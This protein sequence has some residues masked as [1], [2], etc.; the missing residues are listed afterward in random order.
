M[1]LPLA[2]NRLIGGAC[3]AVGL[4][5][6]FRAPTLEKSVHDTWDVLAGLLDMRANRPTGFTA[7]IRIKLT[8][9]LGYGLIIIGVL[10]LA[11]LRLSN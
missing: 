3:V 11:G 5:L 2:E 9:V 7:W 4:Y 1:L 10:M 8:N 6:A